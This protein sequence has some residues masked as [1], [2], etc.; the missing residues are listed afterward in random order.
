MDDEPRELTAEELEAEEAQV[1][2]M[3]AAMSVMRP[4]LSVTAAGVAD[5]LLSETSDLTDS[6]TGESKRDG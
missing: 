6:D 5:V 1:L 3:R 2:P 4:D